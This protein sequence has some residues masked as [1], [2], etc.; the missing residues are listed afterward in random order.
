MYL[1]LERVDGLLNEAQ[2][3]ECRLVQLQDP[4]LQLVVVQDVIQHIHRVITGGHQVHNYLS[5]LLPGSAGVRA[6]VDVIL[7]QLETHVYRVERCAHF[8]GDVPE[9]HTFKVQLPL[10]LKYDSERNEMRA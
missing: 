9:K 10:N 4:I 6:F 7:Q 2:Y 5:G 8:M 3:R 1:Q